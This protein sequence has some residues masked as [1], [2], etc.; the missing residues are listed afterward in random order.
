MRLV[1]ALPLLAG[2]AFSATRI[3][4]PLGQLA[5]W[6]EAPAATLAAEPVVAPC[7]ADNPACARLHLLRAD[8]C[9]G[10]AMAARA[11][12]ATCPGLAEEPHLACAGAGYVTALAQGA[13]PVASLAGNGA[14][15][16]LC[17]AELR[18]APED[19]A[20]AIRLAALAEPPR[21]AALG[22]WAALLRARAGRGPARCAAV[23]EAQRLATTLPAE[24][25]G[26]LL[27]D[28]ALVQG[29]AP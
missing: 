7:P 13:Q 10:L 9:M 8:A 17:R 2:C 1:L 27:G 16:L 5:R 18:P 20:A 25:Q 22:A 12:G 24:Q 3:D 29:C 26:R 4:P 14:Q 19:L 23:A 15:A 21:A 6:R 28:L 11:P